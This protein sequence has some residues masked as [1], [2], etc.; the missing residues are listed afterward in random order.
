M[1]ISKNK[2]ISVL[3]PKSC[4][5]VFPFFTFPCRTRPM[6][7]P[8][9]RAMRHSFIRDSND[10]SPMSWNS[11]APSLYIKAA[12]HT[13]WNSRLCCPVLCCM[14]WVGMVLLWSSAP[15][16]RMCSEPVCRTNDFTLK[17]YKYSNKTNIGQFK[18]NQAQWAA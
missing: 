8:M 10:K 5:A 6:L 12:A 18:A 7:W 15:V 9:T 11:K 16:K 2:N 14:S 1:Q 13:A 4:V 17:K 3:L